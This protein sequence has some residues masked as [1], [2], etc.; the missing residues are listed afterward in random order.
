MAEPI[1]WLNWAKTLQAIAQNGLTFAKDGFD[2]ERY[3]AVR[4]IAAEM[5]SAGSG[6]SIE[7]ILTLLETEVGYATPKVD[8]RAAVFDQAGALL[9]VKERA[10]GLWSLPG[11]WADPC[12]SAAECVVREV[13]EESGY[14]VRVVKLAAAFDRS[15]HPHEPPFASHVYKLFFLCE[16]MGGSPKATLETAECAFFGPDALPPLSVTRI[17]PGQIARL[18]EHHRHPELPTDFD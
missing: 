5:L 1:P 8:V 11:G 4:N 9:F 12:Q 2:I 7:K 13:E 18:F 16:I 17:T 3:Q 15:K 10:D 14:Q 6:V